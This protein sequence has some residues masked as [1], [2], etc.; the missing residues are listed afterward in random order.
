MSNLINLLWSSERGRRHGQIG[1]NGSS[2]SVL[3]ANDDTESVSSIIGSPPTITRTTERQTRRTPVFESHSLAMFREEEID[4]NDISSLASTSH[5]QSNDNTT[6]QYLN[7]VSPIRSSDWKEAEDKKIYI[8]TNSSDR[9]MKQSLEDECV[10]IKK[11][12]RDYLYLTPA[13][14]PTFEQLFNVY[15]S[16]RSP[17][18]K[19]IM[20]ACD[21]NYFGFLKF[22]NTFCILVVFKMSHQ[23]LSN[24]S[25]FLR[26]EFLVR[27]LNTI[28]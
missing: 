9:D 24:V 11:K 19:C 17:L 15:F 23:S 5:N 14:E 22:L 13:Q 1:T 12:V 2:H 8:E 28:V 7:E 21:L 6:F 27:L 26:A 10:M 18:A 25:E 4:Y 16:P 20:S 3:V